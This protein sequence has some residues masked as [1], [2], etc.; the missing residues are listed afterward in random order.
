MTKKPEN[1][2]EFGLEKVHIAKIISE[3][4]L[5]NLTYDTPQALPGAVE[6]TIEPQGETIDFQADNV[7]YYGGSTNKGYTGTLTIARLTEYFQTEILG[8]K[9]ASDGTQSEFA[10]AEK[11][12]FAMMFQIEGDK[13]ATRHVMYKCTVTRP[14]QG[15]KTKS[16]DP[17]TTELSFTSVPRSSD[18]AVK[19]RTTANTTKEVYDGW[20]TNVYKPADGVTFGATEGVVS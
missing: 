6:L 9:L 8:E 1:K 17:N 10:D 5:G 3:D 16:G 7:T 4:A 12:A 11:A 18:K 15:S 20:F 14:K 13:N 19:T 2:I